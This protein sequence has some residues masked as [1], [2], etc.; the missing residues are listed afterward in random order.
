MTLTIADKYFLKARE[1]YPYE[2][3][4]ALENLNYALGYD[5]EHAGANHLMGLM[6]WEQFED[7]EM[8]EYYFEMTLANNPG[9]LGVCKNFSHL[10]IERKAFAKAEKL[11]HYSYKLVGVDMASMLQKEG[12]LNEY[13]KQ[14]DKAIQFYK[15]AQK[16]TYNDTFTD[17]LEEDIKRVKRK[18]G[19][20]KKAKKKKK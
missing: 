10:L 13:Q 18:R 17:T 19:K 7:Y 11:I 8:A 4:G 5:E 15:K 6:H 9:H 1:G 20:K 16:E 14:F 2:L 12:L 3:E